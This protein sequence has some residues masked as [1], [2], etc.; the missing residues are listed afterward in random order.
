MVLD[1]LKF[2]DI[3]G[4]SVCHQLPERTLL[5]GKILMPVCSRCSGIYIGFLFTIVF[6][7]ILFRKRES[8][9]PPVYVIVAA[10]VFILSTIFDGFFSYLGFYNTNNIIRIITGYMFG[11]GISII[12]YPVFVYQ[13]FKNFQRKKIFYNY[14]QFIYFMIFSIFLI[15]VQ[16]L[17]PS[18]LGTFFYYLN[19]FSVI[20]TFYFSN[21]TLFLLIPSFAQKANKIFGRHIILPSVIALAVTILELYFAYKLHIFLS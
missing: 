2:I 11:A 19:G 12:I 4:F 14:K 18:W 5:F 3:I 7:F 9:L 13:Y 15:L 8:D 1:I 10:V 16:I 17:S 6:L 20:F 21:L